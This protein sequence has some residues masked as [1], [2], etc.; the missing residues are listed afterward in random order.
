MKQPWEA[1]HGTQKITPDPP[2]KLP[3]AWRCFRFFVLELIGTPLLALL[4]GPVYD[5]LYL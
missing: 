2:M 1:P 3:E 5:F 4:K